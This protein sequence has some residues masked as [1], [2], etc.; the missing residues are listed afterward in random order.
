MWV[1]ICDTCKSSYATMI[2]DLRAI[3]GDSHMICPECASKLRIVERNE[4][5]WNKYVDKD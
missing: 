3:R 1:L 4:N 2:Y 5:I